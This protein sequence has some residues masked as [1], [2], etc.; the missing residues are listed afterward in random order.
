MGLVP[1][2]S[3]KNRS[4]S[5]KKDGGGGLGSHGS[6]TGR[7][8]QHIRRRIN[9]LGRKERKKLTAALR[10]PNTFRAEDMTGVLVNLQTLK[11]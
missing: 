5:P 10:E 7:G 4:Q 11:K 8:A 3:Q 1:T 6:A 2:K 9:A